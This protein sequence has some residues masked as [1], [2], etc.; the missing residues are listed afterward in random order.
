MDSAQCGAESIGAVNQ[1]YGLFLQ[2]ILASQCG[3]SP[4]DMWPKNYGPTALAEG[5]APVVSSTYN[6]LKSS[7]NWIAEFR[8][9]GLK[10]YDFIVVGSGS[11]GAVVAS[12]LSENPKCKV[13]LLEAGWYP[14]SESTV[15][16]QNNNKR[17]A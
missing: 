6:I 17:S 10:E 2:T 5:N 13:L 11:A 9:L 4:L 1:L 12:R 7:E 3:L 15:S 16:I 8:F 14:P